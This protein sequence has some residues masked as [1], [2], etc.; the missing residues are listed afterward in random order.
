MA[1]LVGI[2]FIIVYFFLFIKNYNVNNDH[3]LNIANKIESH[4]ADSEYEIFAMGDMAGKVS[5]LL[6]KK[7]IQLEGLVGG[8]KV[9][10]KIQKQEKLCNLFSEFNVDIYFTTKI[11]KSGDLYYIEEPAQKSTNVKKMKDILIIKPEKTFHSADL[12][13]YAFNLKNNKFCFDN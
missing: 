11:N 6:D 12:N 1:T 3:I 2:F 8:K 5:Y 4:Y 13:V 9:L 7:L 10:N